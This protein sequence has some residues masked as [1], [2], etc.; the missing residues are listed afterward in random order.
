M[1]QINE[2][3]SLDQMSDPFILKH[4]SYK[5]GIL[6]VHQEIH[7]CSIS[8]TYDVQCETVQVLI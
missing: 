3:V 7:E 4:I 5:G 1:N 2:V 6:D 8:H